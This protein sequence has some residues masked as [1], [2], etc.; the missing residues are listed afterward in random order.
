MVKHELFRKKELEK[1]HFENERLFR[2]LENCKSN[3]SL[4]QLN[5]NGDHY[6]LVQHASKFKPNYGF[7]I[8]KGVYDNEIN[9][10]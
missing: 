1:I 4:G 3:V 2:R 8:N 7:S 6:K 5:Q 9:L 10:K